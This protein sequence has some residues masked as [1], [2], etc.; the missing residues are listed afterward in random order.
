MNHHFSYFQSARS[1]SI[2]PGSVA[3]ISSS[4]VMLRGTILRLANYDF[5]IA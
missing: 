5:R 4:G 3:A 2:E 1:R